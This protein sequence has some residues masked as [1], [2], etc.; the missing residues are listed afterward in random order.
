M[1]RLYRYG[2]FQSSAKDGNWGHEKGDIAG[3]LQNFWVSM[4]LNRNGKP[5]K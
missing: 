4:R 1:F 3:I 5:A 2:S